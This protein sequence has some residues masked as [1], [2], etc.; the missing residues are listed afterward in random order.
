MALQEAPAKIVHC[1]EIIIFPD[2]MLIVI[3]VIIITTIASGACED[4][5]VIFLVNMVT[6]T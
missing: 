3:I 6:S 4:I 2:N 5:I 1:K